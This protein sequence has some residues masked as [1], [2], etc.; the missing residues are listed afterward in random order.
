MKFYPNAKEI[1]ADLH[2]RVAILYNYQGDKLKAYKH[3]MKAAKL[4]NVEAQDNLGIL[5]KESSWACK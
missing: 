5:C 1:T 2:G 3:Y 4:G